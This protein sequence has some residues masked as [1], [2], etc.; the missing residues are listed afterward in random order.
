[1]VLLGVGALTWGDAGGHESRA[2]ALSGVQRIEIDSGS[3]N[4][5]VRYVPGSRGEVRQTRNGWF[6][7]WSGGWSGDASEPLHRLDDGRLVLDTDCGWNCSVDYLV[8]LPT[9]VPVTGRMGS[10]SLEV[11]GMSSVDVEVGS[12]PIELR[13]IDG[14][15]TART[16][17]GPV[18][19]ADITGRVDVESGSGRIEGR[20]LSS[21]DVTARTNSGGVELELLES[22]SVR[23]ETGSGG[24]DLTVPRAAY[25]VDA[26]TGSGSTEIEVDRDPAAERSLE[27]STG[28]GGIDVRAR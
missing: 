6:S 20:D 27:L 8:T 17:S 7:G 2:S 1:M 5:D 26:D 25:R 3:G 23:V 24:I 12:G 28:S 21:R 22:G 19:L 16:G 4:V 11:S 9:A 18:E 13:G 10:G 15:V 14:P